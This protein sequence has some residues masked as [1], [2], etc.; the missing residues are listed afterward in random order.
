VPSAILPSG[1]LTETIAGVT[2]ILGDDLD[3]IAVERAVLGL[4]FT[5]VKL[6]AGRDG[7]QTAGSCATPREAIAGDVCCPVSAQAVPFPGRLK[8]RPAAELLQDALSEDGLRRA[9]GIATLNAL[10]ELCWR[11]RPHRGVDLLTGADAF[12]ATEINAAQR[13]V[14]VGAF[15]PLLKR[16][17]RRRQAFLVLEQNPAMLRPE[18]MPFYCPTEMAQQVVPEADVL[19][20]TGA[21][22]LNDTLEDLLGWARPEARV[23]VVGPT[24]GMLPDPFL[25]RGVDLLGSVRITD[26]DAFLDL[27]AEGGAAPHFLGKSAE[28]IMLARKAVAAPSAKVA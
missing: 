4:F 3:R 17:K 22:L 24:V 28:K 19:L 7:I 1:I 23:T 6:S 14:I 8:G 27:I 21:T 5:G 13:V 9:L 16:L 18:E 15:G 2:D 10:A 20:I 25:A 11:R 12:E 26:P